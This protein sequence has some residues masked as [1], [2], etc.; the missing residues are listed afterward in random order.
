MLQESQADALWRLYQLYVDAARREDEERLDDPARRL[1]DPARRLDDSALRAASE[2]RP[3]FSKKGKPCY[4]S[5]VSCYRKKRSIDSADSGA[6][7]V[8]VASALTGQRPV[9][10]ASVEVASGLTGQRPA[11]QQ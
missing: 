5:L 10:A 3:P 8:E 6:A 1:D 7:S 4:W 9:S 11:S 2:P